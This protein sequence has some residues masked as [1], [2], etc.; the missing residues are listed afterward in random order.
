MDDEAVARY[1]KE[2]PAFF[3]QH[4]E[5]LSEVSVPH[6]HGGAAISLSDRQMRTLRER[7][8]QLEARLAELLQCGEENDV[9]GEK[10]HRL[11]VV[12]VAAASL[13]ALLDALHFNLR[14]D[15]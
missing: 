5:L 1:L 14:E 12:L 11:A 15:F 10:M 3:E 7:N 13:D 9:L 2:N 4:G 6:P 8:P